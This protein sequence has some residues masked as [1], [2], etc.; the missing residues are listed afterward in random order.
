M[1]LTC[2]MCIRLLTSLMC[3]LLTGLMC[4]RLQT[5]LM[6]VSDLVDVYSSFD[7]VDVRF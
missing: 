3:V 4:V 1:F 6:C 2:L 5:C 7:F